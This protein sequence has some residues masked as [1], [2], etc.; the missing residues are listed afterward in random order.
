M[1]VLEEKD[2]LQKEKD[3]VDKAIKKKEDEA[4]KQIIKMKI[5]MDEIKK[6]EIKS[7][8][9]QTFEN[10]LNEILKDNE[11]F[12]KNS[13][14]FKPLKEK[15]DEVLRDNEEAILKKYKIN[16]NDLI[17]KNSQKKK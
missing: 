13:E 14:S 1:A 16:K 11:D 2:R 12:I 17:S 7:D 3:K 8:N 15:I 10:Q 5:I 4:I 6:I 9:T